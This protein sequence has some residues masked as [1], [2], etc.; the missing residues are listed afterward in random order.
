MRI[1]SRLVPLTVVVALLTSCGVATAAALGGSLTSFEYQQLVTTRD[2]VKTAKGVNAAIWD[3]EQIQM[4]TPL[5]TQERSDCISELRLLTFDSVMQSYEKDCSAYPSAAARLQC[6][7]PPYE[8]LYETEATYYRAESRIHQIATTR[9]LGE[10]C[11]DL[12]SDTPIVISEEQLAL[13]E[14]DEI[15]SDAKAGEISG[16]ETVSRKAVVVLQAITKGQQANNGPTSICPHPGAHSGGSGSGS[17]PAA[18]RRAA[19][20]SG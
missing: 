8:K 20:Q 5:L 1:P 15:I 13:A 11:A 12:L 2:K 3:C 4:Q 19:V 14:I 7:L 6:L 17:K 16:F 18:L 10:A 9:G